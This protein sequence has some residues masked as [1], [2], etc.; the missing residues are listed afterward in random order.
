[1]VE[2]EA[3]ER[4]IK[5]AEAAKFREQTARERL[6]DQA[7]ILQEEADKEAQEKVRVLAPART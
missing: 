2:Q 6:H 3:E 5:A 4:R 7:Q 1:M